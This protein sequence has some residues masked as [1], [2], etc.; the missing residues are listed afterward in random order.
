M[1]TVAY[2]GI[3]YHQS[4]LAVVVLLEGQPE[5]IDRVKLP[6]VPK[7]LKNY[8]SKL[9][10]RYFLKTCYEASS[11]GYVFYREMTRWGHSCQVV[12]P[13]KIPKKPGD[14]VKTDFK[15]A[16]NLA[17]Q[18][19][20]GSL[21][22]VHIPSEEEEAARALIRCRRALKEDCKRVKLRISSLL[23]SVGHVYSG[24]LWTQKHENWLNQVSLLPMLDSVLMEYRTQRVYLENRIAELDCQIEAL[25]KTEKYAEKVKTLK[26]LRGIGTLTAMTLVGEL[27]DISRFPTAKALMSFL[28]LTPS[29]YSSSTVRRTGRITRAGNAECRRVLIESAQH[30]RRKPYPTQAMRDKWT[31]RPPEQIDHSIRCM[32]CLHK[33]YLTLQMRKPKNVALVAIA[34][35]FVG[36]I[37]SLLQPMRPAR[38]A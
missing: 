30:Y 28:G 10:E 6:N 17:Y 29:E 1:K 31:D 23:K 24:S 9:C 22:F 18:F 16:E 36:F 38:S 26:T 35:E 2:V 37:W 4:F 19:R 34:R 21:S 3:D 13:S 33:R 14:H 15:D 8:F 25:A 7:N 32:K 27:V 12:A 20:N 11:C 5:P